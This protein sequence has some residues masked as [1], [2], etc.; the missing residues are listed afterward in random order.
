MSNSDD[1]IFAGPETEHIYIGD[2]FAD[3]S[4]K[5]TTVTKCQRIKNRVRGIITEFTF[6]D[7]GFLK[8]REGTKKKFNK[9]HV[10]ELRFMKPE[11]ITTRRNATVCLWS[12]LGIGILALFVSVVLPLMNLAQYT[13]SLTVILTTLAILGLLFFVYRSEVT[14][15]YCTTSGRT[16][17]LSLTGSFGC[18]HHMR[19]MARE[20][21]RA[22]VRASAE[23]GAHDVRYL[24]AEMQA[25][26]KLAETGAITREACSDGTALILSK[27]G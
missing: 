21:H 24:R 1:E 11:P 22:I 6:Y 3:Q 18:D 7:E 5:P 9:E 8:I 20:I 27:F 26:Y 13:I 25:H 23:T 10:L 19:A 17:V 15:Q 16:V 4:R 2:D 14:H 12:S